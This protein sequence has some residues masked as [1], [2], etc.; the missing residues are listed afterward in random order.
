MFFDVNPR[1]DSENKNKILINTE[2]LRIQIWQC[3][4][5]TPYILGKYFL[6]VHLLQHLTKRLLAP[7]SL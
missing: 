5:T 7:K 4:S 2:Y 3:N 1:D 6:K